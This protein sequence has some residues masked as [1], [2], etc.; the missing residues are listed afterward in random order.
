MGSCSLNLIMTSPKIIFIAL[1]GTACGVNVPNP[2]N[3]SHLRATWGYLPS[4]GP[5]TWPS[6]FET[7]AGIS[8]SPIDIETSKVK[9]AD[10]GPIKL[11]AYDKA[12]NGNITNNEHTITFTYTD[13][14]QPYMMGGRL[15]A[16]DVYEFLQLHWHWGSV[17]TQGSEHTI[18]GK[19]YPMELHLVHWNRK[20]GDV[21]TAVTKSDGL[22]VLG[23]FYE[24]SSSDN[25]NLD[26]MLS[27][28]DQVRRRQR[29]INNRKKSKGKKG[30]KNARADATKTVVV[31]ATIRLD[32]LLPS[33]G[34][35]EEYY[36]YQGSLTTPTCDEVVQW[37]VFPTTVPVS[38][39]QLNI[40]RTL[41]DSN[42]VTLNDNYR[43]PLPLN[44]RQ[45]MM[46]KTTS[47]TPTPDNNGAAA[48]AG[49]TGI[50]VGSLATAAGFGLFSL[51]SSE[52]S[53]RRKHSAPSFRHTPPRN[54]LFDLPNVF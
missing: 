7:C 47:P 2:K 35:P 38:E 17:S 20:Y 25:G 39:N 24:V 49:L 28:V 27:V 1:F 30:K 16:G 54:G 42:G 14:M 32:Q 21:G 34:L 6:T 5:A 10:P 9:T 29:A 53:S 22:A 12:M 37:T 33:T 50:I 15:P 36:Y 31:P 40:F 46:R 23:F 48:A 43:P 44:G 18:D 8:Q 13:G 11:V 4:N 3:P 45:V 26:D 41:E 19:E 52:P 51:F